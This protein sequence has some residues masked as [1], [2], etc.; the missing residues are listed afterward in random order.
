MRSR[1]SN[2]SNDKH[3]VSITVT[4]TVF[5]L[6]LAIL[7]FDVTF[8]ICNWQC[9]CTKVWPRSSSQIS[10]SMLAFNQNRQRKLNNR[11]NGLDVKKKILLQ[12]KINRNIG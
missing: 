9:H 1:L 11:K 8:I 4:A 7:L 2:L 6:I 5:Y 3:N 10:Y 12:K